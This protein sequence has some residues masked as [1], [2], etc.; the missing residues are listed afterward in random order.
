MQLGPVNAFMTGWTL[1]MLRRR[2]Y[3]QGA[4]RAPRHRERLRR[5][6]NRDEWDRHRGTTEEAVK[7]PWLKPR[8]LSLTHDGLRR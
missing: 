8:G 5:M 3:T 2:A 1:R 4:V 7:Y 6:R